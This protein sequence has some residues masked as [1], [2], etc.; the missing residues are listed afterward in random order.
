M[1]SQPIEALI[2]FEAERPIAR[3][4]VRPLD[5]AFRAFAA[6]CAA[7]AICASLLL[8][9]FL[10]HAGLRGIAETGI[11][12]LLTGSRWKPEA[13]IFG[14]LP[15]VFGTVASASLAIMLGALP[16]VLVALW[17]SELSPRRIGPLFRRTMEIATALPSVVYGWLALEHLVPGMANVAHLLHPTRAG[18]GGEG[19]A[20]SG[21][22]LAVMIAP[23]VALLSLDAFARV[24]PTMREASVALGASKLRTAFSIVLP[25]A[26]AGVLLAVFFGFARAAGETMAVQMVVGGARVLPETAFSPTTTISAQ[27]VMDMQN[28]RPGTKESDVLYAM[29]LVLLVLS[30]AVVLATR[31][32]LRRSAS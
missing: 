19:L 9:A 31:A 25:R 4:R 5:L 21:L 24:P 32:M 1:V 14:G 10:L 27:I 20:T 22:L 12:S 16:A 13:G 7:L 26:K 8:L 15:L 3:R 30:S 11:V 28:A 2:A 17:V 18:L 29:A 23:T 6:G